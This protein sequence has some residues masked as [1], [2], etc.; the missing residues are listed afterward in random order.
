M[1]S[2]QE[3]R[4][5]YQSDESFYISEAHVGRPR[6]P[7]LLPFL[8][9]RERSKYR[10]LKRSRIA[11]GSTRAHLSEEKSS[12]YRKGVPGLLELLLCA[13]DLSLSF[14]VFLEN[15]HVVSH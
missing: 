10:T 9:K 15:H 14:F 7:R 6:S 8:F 13:L 4:N 5:A 11:R 3:L 12:R 1:G 2:E